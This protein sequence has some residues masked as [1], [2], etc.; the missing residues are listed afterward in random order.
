M[1]DEFIRHPVHATAF[2]EE[3]RATVIINDNCTVQDQQDGTTKESFSN[4][5]FT[6]LMSP[7]WASH[8]RTKLSRTTV[9]RKP[10]PDVQPVE[11][12]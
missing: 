10:A 11:R 3:A 6:I 1:P 2:A 8:G 12:V 9:R 4:L 5:T 7:A